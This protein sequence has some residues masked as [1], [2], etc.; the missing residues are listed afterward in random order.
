MGFIAHQSVSIDVNTEE[1]SH[2]LSKNTIPHFEIKRLL[3]CATKKKVLIRYTTAYCNV[4]PHPPPPLNPPTSTSKTL[5]WFFPLAHTHVPHASAASMLQLPQA[6]QLQNVRFSRNGD[7]PTMRRSPAVREDLCNLDCGNAPS[8]A[9]KR[10][11]RDHH[12]P[13]WFVGIFVALGQLFGCCGA[14]SVTAPPHEDRGSAASRGSRKKNPKVSD[15]WSKRR[16]ATTRLVEMCGDAA[17]ATTPVSSIRRVG[18]SYRPVEARDWEELRA[19][20]RT[21]FAPQAQV[22]YGWVLWNGGFGV[23]LRL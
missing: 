18:R 20:C 11:P 4:D 7:P 21:K 16:V 2:H 23:V 17:C 1:S 13:P 3:T 12:Q 10:N 15:C 9:G 8:S 22:I 6:V 14:G 19:R 5:R